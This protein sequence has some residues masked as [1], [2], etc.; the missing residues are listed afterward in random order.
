MARRSIK[1]YSGLV[2]A[3]DKCGK[4]AERMADRLFY[5]LDIYD[6]AAFR[7]VLEKR[8][9]AIIDAAGRSA[10]AAA[11]SYYS[12]ERRKVEKQR[13]FG[14]IPGF[15]D[16]EKIAEGIDRVCQCVSQ[17]N[18]RFSEAAALD[19]LKSLVDSR[20]RSRGWGTLVANAHG[21]PLRPKCRRKIESDACEYC[22]ERGGEFYAD[23][24]DVND[25]MH[26]HCKCGIDVDFDGSKQERE[27]IRR[28]MEPGEKEE[29]ISAINTVYE[30]RFAGKG[31]AMFPYGNNNYGFTINNFDDYEFLWKRRIK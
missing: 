22:R 19:E 26:A 30:R 2:K 16:Q 20:T 7:R 27:S 18:G 15:N 4:E 31:A 23:P 17:T 6:E 5:S 8:V 12:N 3:I 13:Y 11:L 28:I 1:T 29:V 10:G 24:W 21:D 14:F 25:S 9:P